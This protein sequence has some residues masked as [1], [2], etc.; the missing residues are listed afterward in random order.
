MEADFVINVGTEAKVPILTFSASS[1]CLTSL[2]S[3]FFFRLTQNDLIQV[4]AI[5][6][7]VQNFG[8]RQVVP[9]YEDNSYGEGIIPFL[10]DALQECD[11]HVPYRSVVSE[12]ATDDQIEKE[13]YKLMTMQ[14]RVFVVHMMNLDLC[15]KLFSKAKS[16]GMMSTDYVWIMTG[17]ISNRIN[18]MSYSDRN[19]M[20]GVLGIQTDIRRTPKLKEFERRWKMKFQQDNPNITLDV[21]GFQAHDAIFALAMAVEQF[22]NTSIE[23]QNASDSLKATDLDALKVSQYGPELAKALSRTRFEGIAGEFNVVEGELQSTTYK[24]INIIGGNVKRIAL[25]T[26]QKG[27]VSANTSKVFTNSKCIFEPIKWPGDSFS[28]PKG[29]EIPTN[30]KKLRVGVP[31]KDSLTEF[32]KITKDPNTKTTAVTGFCIDVFNAALEL[33]PYAL[34]YEFIPY[35]NS[36]GSM[37]GTY[38]DLVYQKF[39]AVVGDTTIRANR[40]LYVDFTMPYSESDVGMVVPISDSKSKNAWIFMQPLTWGLWLTTLWEKVVSNSARFV[41]TVWV[42]VMLIVTQSYTANLSSLL[43]VQQ[44]QPT[45]TELNDLLRNGDN[46][47]YSKNSFVRE[48]LIEKGFKNRVKE[49]KLMEDGDKELTKGTAKGGI[50][51]FVGDTPALEFFLAKYCSKYIMVGPISKTNGF[52]FVFPKGSPLVADMSSAI[53]NVTEGKKIMK[54]EANWIKK[55]SNCQGSSSSNI[56]G[57][58]SLGLN[59]FWGLFLVAGIVSVFSL[60]IFFTSFIY[61]HKHVLMSPDSTASTW[62]RIRAIFETFDDRDAS[63]YSSTSSQ[64]LKKFSGGAA[65]SRGCLVASP[66]FGT[67][68]VG[69]NVPDQGNRRLLTCPR[70]PEGRNLIVTPCGGRHQNE[71]LPQ[72]SSLAEILPLIVSSKQCRR[73]LLGS[74]PVSGVALIGDCRACKMKREKSASGD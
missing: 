47:G 33:L 54:I 35:E 70:I 63:Y 37:A 7:I 10:I 25:C 72:E 49:I 46:V 74:S 24:I 3:S 60:I 44:P 67:R 28:V 11:A 39:D 55:E 43:T 40:S 27:M 64:H 26:P 51:A 8:W 17:G 38:D 42:F 9:I 50:A 62:R 19:S 53:L 36:N 66:I 23:Y 14:T 1:P 52:A 21:Y 68:V 12:S 18:S 34:P 16:I 65:L 56:S 2:G 22:G 32:V 13:L 41:I 4:K 73:D 59:S 5:S 48:V 31:V 30:R 20:E 29:W 61:K 45:V 58:N 69:V 6:G 71:A 57:P 15:S